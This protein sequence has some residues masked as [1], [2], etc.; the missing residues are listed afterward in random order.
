METAGSIVKLLLPPCRFFRAKP[1]INTKI[2]LAGFTVTE[3]LA[4]SMSGVVIL[5]VAVKIDDKTDEE[6]RA[7]PVTSKR[8]DAPG[9][10]PMPKFPA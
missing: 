2:L 5:V 1:C 4:D 8:Y 7:S 3:P 9:D 10:I 6:M